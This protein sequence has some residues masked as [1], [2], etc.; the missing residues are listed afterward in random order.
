MYGFTE[1]YVKIE[2]EYDERLVNVVG[3]VHLGG[4]NI[5]GTAVVLQ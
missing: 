4:L 1:N 3:E 2:R 5:E